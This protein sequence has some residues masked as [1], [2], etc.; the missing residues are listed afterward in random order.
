MVKINKKS[1]GFI[2]K[3]YYIFTILLKLKTKMN[4]NMKLCNMYYDKI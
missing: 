3:E 2:L 1:N 4:K